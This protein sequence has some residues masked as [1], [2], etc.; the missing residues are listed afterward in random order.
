MVSL[1]MAERCVGSPV[2]RIGQSWQILLPNRTTKATI[3]SASYVAASDLGSIADEDS[4]P[5]D[6]IAADAPPLAEV[7]LLLVLSSAM[8][9]IS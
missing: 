8:Y 9:L 3:G 2:R 7:C 1:L 5:L 6:R 4:V